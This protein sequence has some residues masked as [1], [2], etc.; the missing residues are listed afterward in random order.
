MVKPQCICS[1]SRSK[2]AKEAWEILKIVYVDCGLMRR[3][4]LLRSLFGVMQNFYLCNSEE[5]DILEE[6]LII[7]EQ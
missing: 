6:D 1:C 2:S 7:L 5:S 3:L 4:G